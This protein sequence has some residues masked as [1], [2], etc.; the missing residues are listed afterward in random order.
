MGPR[1]PRRLDIEFLQHL[2][3]QRTIVSIQQRDGSLSFDG[4]RG[5]PA[6][7]VQQNVR[8]EKMR[9][10][11]SAA[12]VYVVAGQPVR[13]V[14]VGNALAKRALL[15]LQSLGFAFAG[16]KLDQELLHQG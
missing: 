13:C 8:V 11:S 15:P 16:R 10:R 12:A 4:I 5:V 7:R 1:G 9:H 3:R 2:N 6:D 14:E